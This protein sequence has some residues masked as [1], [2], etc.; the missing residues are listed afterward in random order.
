MAEAIALFIPVGEGTEAAAWFHGTN[1][2]H[3]RRPLFEQPLA[4]KTPARDLHRPLEF[5]LP[6]FPKELP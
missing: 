6:Y 3:D 4:T 5:W 1:I 2:R